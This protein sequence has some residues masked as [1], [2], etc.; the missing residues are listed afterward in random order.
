MEP[1]IEMYNNRKSKND[2][3][4]NQK[5]INTLFSNLEMIRK[6]NNEFFVRYA[7][8][9]RDWSPTQ[10]IG[11]VFLKMV[12]IICFLQVRVPLS[13]SIIIRLIFSKCTQHIAKPM[14]LQMNFICKKQKI[15]F[16]SVNSFKMRN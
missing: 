16:L 4:L 15:I 10:T 9:I 3:I 11:D 13:T 2:Y 7:E 6:I 12:C 8:K 5:E 14:M 1:L